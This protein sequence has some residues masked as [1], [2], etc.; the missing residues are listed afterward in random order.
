MGE[1]T[2]AS[3]PQLHEALQK[4]RDETGWV[5]RGHG[6]PSYHLIPKAGREPYCGVDDRVIFRS[7][8]LRAIEYLTNLPDNDWDWL[9]VAQ[10]HG[11]ATRLLDWTSN[12]LNAA[13]FAVERF[14]DEPAV[15]HAAKFGSRIFAADK[16]PWELTGVAQFLPKG[17][18]PRITR[19]GGCF[20]VHPR[21]TED[22]ERSADRLEGLDRLV[23]SKDYRRTLLLELSRY[24]VNRATLFPD[25]DGLSEFV[26]WAA[27]EGGYVNRSA[28]Q[29]LASLTGR[30]AS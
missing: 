22:L 10:H 26:N 18:V 30:T 17:V 28:E 6:T 1:K 16:S 27:S 14:R 2:I 9:A 11:L 13:Y 3:F 19:Q 25:L 29:G 7:W 20:S 12:P 23:I 15:I 5:F 4:Y 8:R 21:P 24:G